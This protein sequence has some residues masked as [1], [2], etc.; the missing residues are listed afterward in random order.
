M[1]AEHPDLP[2]ADD[3]ITPREELASG[4]TEGAQRSLA[5]RI[6]TSRNRKRQQ[7]KGAK[8]CT[9]QLVDHVDL[10]L[11]RKH[12]HTPFHYRA[13]GANA[14]PP[15]ASCSWCQT[16][17]TTERRPR[18][19][20]RQVY[21]KTNI[22]TACTSREDGGRREG[23]CAKAEIVHHNTHRMPNIILLHLLGLSEARREQEEEG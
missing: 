20:P 18:L 15:K 10:N 1:L 3:V 9:Q 6:K 22:E 21:N 2:A 13:L 17:W 11:R 14:S 23:A 5:L 19:A 4:Q 12:E 8:S 16:S 7:N